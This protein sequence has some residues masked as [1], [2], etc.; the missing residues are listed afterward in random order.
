MGWWGG[1]EAGPDDPQ[2]EAR[3]DSVSI[4]QANGSTT[5]TAAASQSAAN[6]QISST[7]STNKTNSLGISF[8]KSF[9]PLS[10]NQREEVCASSAFAE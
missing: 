10:F 9:I 6:S 8:V 4:Y 1:G 5:H 7:L 2:Y 3:G